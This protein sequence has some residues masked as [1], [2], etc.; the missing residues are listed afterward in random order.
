M[1]NDNPG[2]DAIRAENR[3]KSVEKIPLSNERGW[4]EQRQKLLHR[5]IELFGHK[6]LEKKDFD[7][8]FIAKTPSIL[9]GVLSISF[10]IPYKEQE[11]RPFLERIGASLSRPLPPL[12]LL[13]SQELTFEGGYF[14]DLFFS[15]ENYSE[16]KNIEENLSSFWQQVKNGW[17]KKYF[18]TY[19]QPKLLFP[20]NKWDKIQ[21]FSQII[22]KRFLSIFEEDF[23]RLQEIFLLSIRQGFEKKRDAQHLFKITCVLFFFKKKLHAHYSAFPLRREVM[24]KIFP[25]RIYYPFGIGK[26]MTIMVGL[27]HIEEYEHFTQRHLLTAIRRILP[28]TEYN[29]DSLYIYNLEPGFSIY[30]LE[31]EKRDR[32]IFTLEE[33]KKIAKLLPSEIPNS[34]EYLSPS[35]LVPRNEEEIMR[36]IVTLSNELRFI[37]DL[38]QAIIS[39]QKQ[40]RDL[41]HFTIILVRILH[42]D[43]KM[44]QTL[45]HLLPSGVR[46]YFEKTTHVGRVRKRNIKEAH[47][48]TLE[49]KSNAFL[50]HNGSIDLLRARQLI[51]QSLEK[52]IGPYRDYNGGL[53]AK[54]KQLLS[55]LKSQLLFSKRSEHL[56]DR[57]YYSLY[58]LLAQ[59]ALPP[60]E[61]VLLFS[62]FLDSIGLDL[63]DHTTMK[64]KIVENCCAIVLVTDDQELKNLVHRKVDQNYEGSFFYLRGDVEIEHQF[65]LCYLAYEKDPSSSHQLLT[66]VESSIEKRREEK[67]KKQLLRLYLPKK[68]IYLDPRIGR[69]RSSGMVIQMLYEGLF[70]KSGSGQLKKALVQDFQISPDEKKYTFFL[71]KSYWSNEEFVKAEDFVFSWKS[72]IDPTFNCPYAFLFFDIRN[73]EKAKLGLVPLDDVG[74]YAID[75]FTLCVELERKSTLFLELTA[76]WL[77]SPLWHQV[78]Q[79]H[80]G[81]AYYKGNNFIC[82]GPFKLE[83]SHQSGRIELHRNP[84]YWN[85]NEVL[86]EKIHIQLLE[87]EKNSLKMGLNSEFDWLGDPFSKIPPTIMHQLKKKNQIIEDPREAFVCMHL[88]PKHLAFQSKKNRQA[89]SCVVSREKLIHEILQ[90]NDRRA[91]GFLI[92]DY[93]SD[94]L[95]D[96]DPERAQLLFKEGCKELGISPEK[97]PPIQLLLND[98]EEHQ[99]L[100]IAIGKCLVNIFG[101]KVEYEQLNWNEYF[102]AI[103]QGN[104]GL[105]LINWYMRYDDPLYYLEL[106]LHQIGKNT[107]WFAKLRKI[108]EKA[109]ALSSNKDSLLLQ[110][111]TILLDE[112]P[113]VPLFFQK[114]RYIKNP[115][116]KKTLVFEPDLIDFT[117]SYF[118]DA[119]PKRTENEKQLD[120]INEKFLM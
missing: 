23:F 97:I 57:L 96:G 90:N 9:P 85:K 47:L 4:Q 17:E 52:M 115:L 41:L 103:L 6:A 92:G 113:I 30:Y 116:L 119:E 7:P 54:Q 25:A 64:S 38:P 83:Q 102:E 80:P 93:K 94:R 55:I 89:F 104:F 5:I 19:F 59:T 11:M 108:I 24:T 99:Q 40:K 31:I 105:G 107:P 33:R 22:S 106:F 46:I 36:N 37:R 53:L 100:S 3:V 8:L 118:E 16:L 15:V 63:P 51:A 27:N 88:N 69:D 58:P 60:E 10:I 75:D 28:H 110:A 45:S 35:L 82:N 74:V 29:K 32:Q 43:S 44:I 20:P 26:V 68:E 112:M 61:G 1:N 86:M 18:P 62:L 71:K 50:S 78:D 21:S 56:I 114:M 42:N 87:D 81:W 95:I 34:V 48:F 67:E 73:A 14:L 117:H 111:E 2:M 66:I 65:Y 77:F 13:S 70:R 72:L 98:V 79:N 39:F 76:N 91:L 12:S 109:K 49:V 101:I 84:L 120:K